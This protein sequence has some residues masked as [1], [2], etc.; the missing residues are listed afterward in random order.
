MAP[1]IDKAFAP[2]LMQHNYFTRK[3]I[4]EGILAF[5]GELKGKMLDFG[6][7]SKPYRNCFTVDQYVGVDYE[8]EGHSHKNEQ[9]DVFYD[10]KNIPFEDGYFDSVLC[11]E[12]IEHVFNL[13]EVL[14]EINRVTRKDAKLLFTC[15]FMWN[16]HEVPYD[17]ARYTRF[18]LKSIFEKNGFEIIEFKKSGTFV[19]TIAQM[20][21]LYAQESLYP[22]MKKVFFLRWIYKFFFILS[23]NITG[24]VLD[25]ILPGNQSLYLNN[26][27]LARKV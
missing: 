25:K 10:G 4:K 12:V 22:L 23:P 1:Q 27:L 15:P 16:E 9:I 17:F 21:S 3:G 24:I 7:G 13:D 19:T 2:D 5:A 20:M 11:T 8:N 6:C 26:I 18:A 14:K